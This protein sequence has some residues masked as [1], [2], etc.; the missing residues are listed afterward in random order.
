MCIV[1]QWISF[2]FFIFILLVAPEISEPPT[3]RTKEEGHTVEFS[4]VVAGYPTPDVAWTK[5]GVELNLT[6]DVRLNVSSNNGNHHLTISSV[7]QSDAGKYRCVANNS[8]DTATSSPA[9][10]SVKCECQ[11]SLSL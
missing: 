6:R 10:L 3:S 4:C 11:S 9:T 5:N 8:L 2:N 7:Q 1:L